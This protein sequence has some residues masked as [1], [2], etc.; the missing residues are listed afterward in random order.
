MCITVN[1]SRYIHIIEFRV[2]KHFPCSNTM[3]AQYFIS[4][5]GIRYRQN[6]VHVRLLVIIYVSQVT[7]GGI[8]HPLI[9][10]VRSDGD[11]VWSSK[12][13]IIFDFAEYYLTGS[14]FSWLSS[15]V[16]VITKYIKYFTQ[17]DIIFFTS[18]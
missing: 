3:T 16:H 12:I 8:I 5:N 1:S 2:L 9:S 7:C 13:L 18:R 10:L 14:L 15:C 4:Q 6:S 11:D 17:Y